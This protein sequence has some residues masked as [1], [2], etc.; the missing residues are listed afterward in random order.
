MGICRWLLVLA[1]V[2][3]VLAD[4]IEDL[5]ADLADPDKAAVA[6]EALI[7]RGPEAVPALIGEAWE[8]QSVTAR[9]W[10]I[11]CLTEIG[12]DDV[13]ESMQRLHVDRKQPDLVRTW[14]AACCVQLAPDAEALLDLVALS[15][16]FPAL[17]R[18]LGMRLGEALA[19]ETDG[20]L[21]ARL[22][23]ISN[24]FPDLQPALIPAIL[25]QGPQAMCKVMLTHHAND[26]R[27]SATAYLGTMAMQGD[28]S[29][30]GHVADAYRFS[31]EVEQVPWHGGPL[32][33]PSI[34]YT[35]EAARDLCGQLVRWHL[36]CERKGLGEEQNQIH[37]NLRSLELAR[38]AGYESPGWDDIGTDQWLLTWGRTVG[39]VAL[40][41]I[42]E[43]Q[44]VA[45]EARYKK[46]V[47]SL[48]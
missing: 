46:L 45:A 48:P 42:L 36:W 44:G 30:A 37:N 35:Q 47:D 18:P 43:E 14:A 20:K 40:R 7:A 3:P 41:A 23:S 16:S 1:C 39:K 24:Q 2:A 21:L 27:W 6:S 13:R 4:E 28:D 31:N 5:V 22:L 15:Q 33:I 29:V 26:V 8:G 34:S 25:A 17:V 38:M 10:A 11:V 32:Y 12:G 9:G 19:A